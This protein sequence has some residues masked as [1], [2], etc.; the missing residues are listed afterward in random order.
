MKNYTLVPSEINVCNM[1]CCDFVKRNKDIIYF[2]NLL[3]NID[4]SAMATQR[5]LY[6]I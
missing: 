3:E 1:F 2:I 6:A 5:C 4:D